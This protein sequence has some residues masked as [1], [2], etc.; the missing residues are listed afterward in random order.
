MLVI[1]F[2]PLFNEHQPVKYSEISEHQPTHHDP[3]SPMMQKQKK[4]Y[5]DM[6]T[7]QTKQ[8]P[9]LNGQQTY[10]HETVHPTAY[11]AKEAQM[12]GYKQES[13]YFQKNQFVDQMKYQMPTQMRKYPGQ[14]ND[15]FS[16]LQKF[17]PSM[18]RSIMS[19]HHIRETQMNYPPMGQN[20]MYNQNQRYYPNA[21]QNYQANAYGIQPYNY[22]SPQNCNYNRQA[23]MGRF[24][25]TMDR[26][27]S[28][29]RRTAYPPEM[30]NYSP[31]QKISPSYHHQYTTPE[32]AQHYQHRR[33]N[34]PQEYYQPP[35][36][37]RNP[38]FMPTNNPAVEVPE[39]RVTPS[40]DLKQFIE[41]WAEDENPCD[42]TVLI[43]SPDD[44]PFIENNQVII[45]SPLENGQFV[46]KNVENRQEA[47]KPKDCMVED[48][49]TSKV[50]V[51]SD[52]EL[53]KDDTKV[54]KNCSPINLDQ[55]ETEETPRETVISTT[56]TVEEESPKESKDMPVIDFSDEKA[57]KEDAIEPKPPEVEEKP[58]QPPEPENKIE[59][60]H[61][62][63]VEETVTNV[64]DE[65]TPKVESP[66]P[67]PKPEPKPPSPPPTPV[68]PETDKKPKSSS[69]RKRRIF[70]VDDIINNIGRK[71]EK[72]LK[73]RKSIHAT[74][75]FLDYE[76]RNVETE[77]VKENLE[78]SDKVPEV[79]DVKPET[80]APLEEVQLEQTEEDVS[81]DKEI[82]STDSTTDPDAESS[83]I[84]YRSAIKIEENSVLLHIAG[85]LVEINVNIQNGKKVITVVPISDTTV[86]DFNDNY[87]TVQENVQEDQEIIED[88]A[89]DKTEDGDKTEEIVEPKMDDLE[90][91]VAEA[92]AGVVEEVV[93]N[94]ANEETIMDVQED[95]AQMEEVSLDVKEEIVAPDTKT[96]TSEAETI[97]LPKTEDVKVETTTES[98]NKDDS[99]LHQPVNTLDLEETKIVP[100]EQTVQRENDTKEAKPEK[101]KQT[102]TIT[103]EELKPEV[104]SAKE[105]VDLSNE[106]IIGD[107]G[108]ELE[109]EMDLQNDVNEDSFERNVICTK[110]A[111][112]AY[113]AD[114]LNTVK[115]KKTKTNPSDDH[116]KKKITKDDSQKNK[117]ETKREKRP[118]TTDEKSKKEEVKKPK[119][120]KKQKSEPKADEDDDEEHVSFKELLKAR[121]LKKLKKLQESMN[122]KPVESEPVTKKEEN[123]FKQ[124]LKKE[125]KEPACKEEDSKNLEGILKKESSPPKPVRKVSFSDEPIDKKLDETEGKC[126]DLNKKKRLSLEDY[127]NRKRKLSP[128]EEVKKILVE[129]DLTSIHLE[130]KK[131]PKSLEELSCVV[132][133]P[134]RKM[135]LEETSTSNNFYND[136]EETLSPKSTEVDSNLLSTFTG[137]LSTESQPV[138]HPV[139]GRKDELQM[140]KEQVDSKLSSLN[141]NIPKKSSAQT[142]RSQICALEKKINSFPL[143]PKDVN[144]NHM[145]MNRFLNKDYLTEDEMKKIKQIIQYKRMVEHMSKLKS[146]ENGDSYEI[147]KEMDEDLKLHLKKIP[148]EYHKKRKRRFRNL[149]A[150]DSDSDYEI[151]SGDY[152]VV[153][154]SCHFTGVPKLIIKRKTDIT[155]PVVRLERLDMNVIK[156]SKWF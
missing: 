77:T 61:P 101:V 67:Q 141:L 51:H 128:K 91:V 70:S 147:R 116:K 132:K 138:K 156:K 19:E 152:S 145:L 58:P 105:F 149:H 46:I 126:N 85:E 3:M 89:E 75:K 54:D 127:N 134:K 124:P 120:P 6:M 99:S 104:D 154:Q 30:V 113:D 86:V 131:R 15:F 24:P 150:V 9:D 122:N 155:Q 106:I 60:E 5:M 50:V 102:E 69:R 57:P 59:E 39:N 98:E 100:P 41:N 21:V 64:V 87:E 17:H 62:E 12:H 40:N 82:S 45:T 74:Q 112:K 129:A 95:V 55:M 52:V 92:E 1:C 33:T 115:E 78:A 144:E 146:M 23:Q 83:S 121:K 108:L 37:C 96:V 80:E 65:Q 14:E 25:P 111:K 53:I 93:E 88:V 84:Q 2:S 20:G 22:G 48:A 137:V 125:E 81:Q 133:E 4:E 66:K 90:M 42:P 72:E 71:K 8:Y 11:A 148:D 34:M 79:Q 73:R 142:L 31:L 68:L 117:D 130:V 143:T 44:L 123:D 32:Y 10:G 27:L 43:V 114:F 110:A 16:Q 49:K 36:Q 63:Q 109:V 107:E 103:N 47:E 56:K 7:H 135:S 35:Q 153:Q 139:N 151:N 97:E 94:V 118:K 26:S 28:P 18:A 76:R 29:A 140:V 119:E 38:Q 13:Q 136:W